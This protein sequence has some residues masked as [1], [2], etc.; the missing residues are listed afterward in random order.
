MAATVTAKG[1]VTPEKKIP[2][3]KIARGFNDFRRNQE[4]RIKAG[5]SRTSQEVLQNLKAGVSWIR[6]EF[7]WSPVPPC[8]RL[9]RPLQPVL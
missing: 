7:P 3:R 5:V 8:S 6:K 4:Q 1:Q 9:P 2:C